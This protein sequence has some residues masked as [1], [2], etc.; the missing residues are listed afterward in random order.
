MIYFIGNNYSTNFISSS[1]RE[2]LEYFK[3]EEEIAFDIETTGF[4]VYTK[5]ILSYQVGNEKDQFVVDAQEHPITLI[6]SLLETKTLLIHNASF[7]VNFLYHYRIIP[8]KIWDTFLVEAVLNKGDKT[9]RKA[10]DV[11]AYRYCKA[12][13]DKQ[14]RGAIHKEGLSERVIEYAANDVKYLHSIKR[15]QLAIVNH[16]DLLQSVQLEN[17]FVRALTYVKYCGIY[18]NPDDW[19]KKCQEDLI[20]R[21]KTLKDLDDWV[22]DNKL[23]T[24]I[25]TQLSFSWIEGQR[26]CLI[27]WS[28]SKQVIKLFKELG[29]DVSTDED[30]ESV[31]VKNLKSQENKFEILPLYVKHKKQEK[32]ITTYGL[33][34]LN[35]INPITG[36]VHTT[37]MQIMDTGRISSGD[38]RNNKYSIN[39]QNIPADKRTRSCFQPMEGN[40]FIDADYSGQEQI[41]FANKTMEPNLIKFYRDKLGDMHSFIASKI[42]PEIEGTPLHDIPSKF[43][44]QRQAAKAAGFAINY[45]GN[46]LTIANNLNISLE[47]GSFIY[48]AY[49]KAF[50]G[51][52]NYFE[53]VTKDALT[54]GYILFNDIIK[55]KCFIPQFYEL[56]RLE[57]IMNR[58][59]FWV[60]YREHKLKN[61]KVFKEELYPIVRKKFKLQSSISRMSLNYPIQG[62]SAEITKIATIYF[63]KYLIENNLLF[64]VLIVNLIHDEILLEVPKEMAESI[65]IVLKQCMEKAGNIFCKTVKLEAT[66]LITDFWEH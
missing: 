40:A 25:D 21:T 5:K 63:F 31:D 34:V 56:K 17:E 39:L 14:I 36:R 51:I 60:F 53:H 35:T 20:E 50:P 44:V 19:N 66:P 6:K 52:K 45:G 8:I 12:N 13:L 9:V 58:P 38:K 62:T 65:S 26:R 7:D 10:L 3:D 48:D 22:I 2:L 29:I 41:V 4:D 43:K 18:L 47:E 32:L 61:S 23:T 64:K 42:Y 1:I 46:G 33:D 11:V 24:Y 59:G 57:K 15:K 49:F 55:S 28:S 54:K 30:K 27:N 37:F 16:K